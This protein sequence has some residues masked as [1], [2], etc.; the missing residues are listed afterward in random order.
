MLLCFDLNTRRSAGPLKC[1]QA[2]GPLSRYESSVIQ[3][4]HQVS[5]ESNMKESEHLTNGLI[6]DRLNNDMKK[7]SGSGRIRCC[8][9]SF[10]AASLSFCCDG[11]LPLSAHTA[12]RL[13]FGLIR[14]IK[15]SL[16]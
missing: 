15:L 3:S 11:F 9:T 12:G 6:G 13:D 1:L 16:G 4:R 14:T 10:L 8:Q 2:Q 7:V 5:F